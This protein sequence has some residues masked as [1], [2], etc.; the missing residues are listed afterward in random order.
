LAT[1][2]VKSQVRQPLLIILKNIFFENH[3]LSTMII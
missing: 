2:S 1:S 3:F